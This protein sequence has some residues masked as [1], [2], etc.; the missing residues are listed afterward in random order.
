MYPLCL[1][2]SQNEVFARECKALLD[3]TEIPRNSALRFVG[4]YIDP[5]C[6]LLK[7][8]GRSENA[9]HPVHSRHPIIMAPDHPLIKLIIEDCHKKVRLSGVEH[10][11]SILR[12]Q[13]YPPKATGPF[14]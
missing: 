10:T 1:L 6:G 5:D 7:V 2:V 4:P 8:D 13:C 14:V 11:L 12:E 9:E 3:G